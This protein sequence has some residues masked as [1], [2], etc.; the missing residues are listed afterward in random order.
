MQS[1][2]QDVKLDFRRVQDARL[3][4]CGQGQ[5]RGCSKQ[6][7]LV[8]HSAVRF[9]PRESACWSS[10]FVA[11][12]V[13]LF[14]LSHSGL[15]FY[16]MVIGNRSP[17]S[18]LHWGISRNRAGDCV[19]R[20]DLCVL[21]GRFSWLTFLGRP[22]LAGLILGRCLLLLSLSCFL[23][24][25]E[26]LLSADDF[27][28]GWGSLL[29]HK[30]RKWRPGGREREAG[31]PEVALKEGWA[32]PESRCDPLT[33]LY[34]GGREDCPR[35]AEQAPWVRL[36]KLS[37][38]SKG[39]REGLGVPKE[40]GAVGAGVPQ[41]YCFGEFFRKGRMSL[42]SLGPNRLQE[43]GGSVVSKPHGTRP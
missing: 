31:S 33:K 27:A 28:A 3:L 9:L 7:S 15:H 37:K 1:G 21:V 17:L 34:I 20:R 29:Q 30:G 8:G 41:K 14:H 2:N 11:P 18:S 40:D 10:P 19:S 42:D 32:G 12:G 13:V 5:V 22:P 16:Q 38:P 43:R 35:Y 36:G 6:A 23:I 25:G 4:V 26:E 39:C 24:P